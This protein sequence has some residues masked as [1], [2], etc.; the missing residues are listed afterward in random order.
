VPISSDLSGQAFLTPADIEEITKQLSP[1]PDFE[2]VV[3][4]PSEANVEDYQ[5]AGATWWLEVPWTLEAAL[6]MAR[7]GPRR[8]GTQ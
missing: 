6:A 4:P 3:T 7:A 2:V 8:A 5:A 1:P